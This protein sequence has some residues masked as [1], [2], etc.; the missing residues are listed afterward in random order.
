MSNFLFAFKK[1]KKTNQNTLTCMEDTHE[2]MI[3]LDGYHR[4]RAE[5]LGSLHH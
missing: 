2:A 1:K 3:A 4:I 5:C